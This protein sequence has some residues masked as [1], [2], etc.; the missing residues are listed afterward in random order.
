MEKKKSVSSTDNAKK[1]TLAELFAEFS[2]SPKGLS[3]SEAKRR[4]E[5]YGY[6][7]IS[8][9]KVSPLMKFLGY[10]WGPIPSMPPNQPPTSF[11]LFRAFRSSSTP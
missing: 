8:E 10:F 3:S 5:E 7:E 1:A 11:S 2:S 9:K 6:N 4:I